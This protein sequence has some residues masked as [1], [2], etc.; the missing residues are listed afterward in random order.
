VKYYNAI[1]CQVGCLYLLFAVHPFHTTLFITC[2]LDHIS[3]RPLKSRERFVRSDDAR[4]EYP[5]THGGCQHGRRFT[6]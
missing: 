5:C 3:F 2:H 1:V 4:L 6:S